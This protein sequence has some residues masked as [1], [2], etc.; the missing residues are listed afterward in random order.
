MDF[1]QSMKRWL[2]G[3]F[4][5]SRAARLMGQM[6]MP[7]S[8]GYLSPNWLDN[9]YEQVKAYKGWPAVAIGAIMNKTAQISPEV[10]VVGQAERQQ[11]KRGW[12]YKGLNR[13]ERRKALTQLSASED[14]EPLPLS[15]PL[16]Q[17]L[18]HPNEADSGS[19]FIKELV[20]FLY[21]CGNA[22]LWCPPSQAFGYPAEMWVM[23]SHWMFPRAGKS[24]L[25][26]HYDVRPVYSSVNVLEIPVEEIVHLKFK[27]PLSK[28]DGYAPTT[29]GA[30]WI[31]NSAAIEQ[32]RWHM[33]ANMALLGPM[34]LLDEQQVTVTPEDIERIENR[35]MSRFSGPAKAGRPI[36]LGN[37]KDVKPYSATPE[38][39]AYHESSEQARDYVLAL[40]GV[41]RQVAGFGENM[42]FGSNLAVLMWFCASTI[43]NLT[44]TLGEMFTK[45]VAPRYPEGRR[46]RV[47]WP[48]C[49]PEDPAQKLAEDIAWLDHGVIT[50]NEKRE[51]LGRESYPYGG[52]DPIM[53]IGNAPMPFA[54][55]MDLEDL[56]FVLPRGSTTLEIAQQEQAD[57]EANAEAGA[58]TAPEEEKPAA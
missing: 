29:A 23:P 37:V 58:D 32:S 5:K 31:D 2:T 51:E 57:T 12:A 54:T 46:L 56:D 55:G 20:L 41:P 39:M 17:L 10:A 40:F 44:H 30:I 53:P 18:R 48:D 45:H 35:F 3:R 47:Y 38:E 6:S 16:W 34:L 14:L 19:D 8:G 24:G 42:T 15:H 28:I 7:F 25:L 1:W 11:G 50:I 9:R 36:I 49:T 21:L 13:L 52:D 22:Y 43:N 26:D 33:F 4:T 27:S